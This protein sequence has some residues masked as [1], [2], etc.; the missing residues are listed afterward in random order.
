MN[1]INRTKRN[2]SYQQAV[3]DEDNKLGI[4]LRKVNK[5]KTQIT[6]NHHKPAHDKC[7]NDIRIKY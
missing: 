7:K 6:Q 2:P 3:E 5:L 4:T 1:T